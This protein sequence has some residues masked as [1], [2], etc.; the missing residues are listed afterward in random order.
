YGYDNVGRLITMTEATDQVTL[1]QYDAADHLLQVTSNYLPGQPQNYLNEYNLITRY[2]YD[3]AGYSTVV[4]NTLGQVDLTFYNNLGQVVTQ[5]T[6]YDGAT[7]FP[8]L[9]TDFSNP[10][11]EYN[12]CTLTSYDDA[13]RVIA[14]TD[15]LGRVRRTFYDELGRIAGTVENWSGLITTASELSDCLELPQERD[16]DVCTLYAYDPAGNTIIITDTLGRMTRNFYD[17]L[18]RVVATISNWSGTITDTSG[19]SAC[20]GLPVQ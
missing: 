8:V 9:C 20:L 12:L 18:N 10:D 13:G 3:D 16:N 5:V 1:Y 19:L 2:Q 7:S 15:A 6:N 14:S 11:P 17:P 4:T